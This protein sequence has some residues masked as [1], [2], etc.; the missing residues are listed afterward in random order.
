VYHNTSDWK[1]LVLQVGGNVGALSGDP[2]YPF[3]KLRLVRA[4][5]FEPLPHTFNE[6]SRNYFDGQAERE[7]DGVVTLVNAAICSTDSDTYITHS[8]APAPSCQDNAVDGVGPLFDFYYRSHHSQ[9]GSLRPL[10]AAAS[11]AGEDGQ[12]NSRPEVSTSLVKCMTYKTILNEHSLL[13]SSSDDTASVMHARTS[14]GTSSDSTTAPPV[15]VAAGSALDIL[16]TDAEG[17]DLA[18]LRQVFATSPPLLYPKVLLFEHFL[19]SDTHRREVMEILD[20]LGYICQL[21]DFTAMDTTCERDFGL[22]SFAQFSHTRFLTD[23][24]T[25]LSGIEC[26]HG[27]DYLC[28]EVLSESFSAIVLQELQEPPAGRH[29]QADTHAPT[30]FCEAVEFTIRRS[31]APG[32]VFEAEMEVQAWQHPHNTAHSACLSLSMMRESCTQLR[33][34]TAEAWASCAEKVMS[35]HSAY[36]QAFVTPV[37]NGH[38][39]RT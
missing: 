9:M 28:Q 33:R 29:V 3:A 39:Q 8:Q 18:L 1:P 16:V 24:F 11:L 35:R 21:Q 23:A 13:L 10:V 12:K 37:S 15:P 7:S 32:V 17:Y 20:R 5:I 30:H 14:S 34:K 38:E 36:A 27:L 2:V 25:A 4:L 19:I 6:L 22:Q 26:A 31:S